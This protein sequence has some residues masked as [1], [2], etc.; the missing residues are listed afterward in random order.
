[1]TE[2]AG[3]DAARLRPAPGTGERL[4]TADYRTEFRAVQGD[5]RGRGSWK[6]ERRQEFVESGE[7][8]RSFQEGDWAAAVR[9]HE[10]Q[11]SAYAERVER[12]R[13]HGAP[14]RRVRVVEQ[15][16]TPYLQWE[17]QAF[18]VQAAAGEQIRVITP[19]ALAGLEPEGP[20][21]EVVV[22]GDRVLYEVVYT[23]RGALDG[24]VRHVDP[25]LIACWSGFVEELYAA[26]EDLLVWFGR[27]VSHLP[28]PRAG[29]RQ[30]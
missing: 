18:R 11:H 1:M 2:R 3:W 24:A 28:P 19:A 22:L 8:W 17:M 10:R 23:E 30:R 25:E 9:L 4:A 14:F 26:G 13:E 15:P 5:L 12:L 20:L 6:F 21:P 7:S 16:L 27:E 29:A